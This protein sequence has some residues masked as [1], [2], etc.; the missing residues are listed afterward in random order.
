MTATG[1]R[2]AAV[3][4][5]AR[6]LLY[7]LVST[8]SPSG[9]EAA[10]ADRLAAFFEA[11]GREVWLDEVGNVRAPADDSLLL[12]SHVDTVPGDIP[13]AVRD[14]VLW[15]VSTRPGR[16]RRWPSRPSRRG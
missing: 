2:P 5:E 15:G 8:P 13:V 14:E 6:E 3:D 1:Q 9:E 7:D 11:H 4:T 12:T 16:S 10:A